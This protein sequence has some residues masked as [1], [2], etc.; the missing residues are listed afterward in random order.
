M[1]LNVHSREISLTLRKLSLVNVYWSKKSTINNVNGR[2]T[3]NLLDENCQNNRL[4]LFY[5]LGILVNN[6]IVL[7]T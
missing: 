5:F 1:T 7:F 3:S 2:R 6:R 4:N